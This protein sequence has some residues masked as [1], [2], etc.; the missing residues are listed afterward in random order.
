ML[1]NIALVG[2]PAKLQE[3]KGLNHSLYA[4]DIT[5]WVVE[6]CDRHIEQTLQHT[7][8]TVEQY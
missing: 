8:E 4:N 7:I 2:L 5:L 6:G 1:F 3:N